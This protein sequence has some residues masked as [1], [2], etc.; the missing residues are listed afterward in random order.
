MKRLS[1]IITASLITTYLYHRKN[2]MQEH[3]TKN[4]NS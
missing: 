2:I 3:T 4:C 1:V